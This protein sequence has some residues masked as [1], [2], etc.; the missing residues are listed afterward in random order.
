MPLSNRVR[1]GLVALAVCLAGASGVP[2]EA[3]SFSFSVAGLPVGTMAMSSTT[4]GTSYSATADVDATGLVGF[5]T[6]FFFHGK[7]NGTVAADGTVVPAWF[8]AKSKSSRAVR[9]T[10]IDWKGGTPTKVTIVPPRDDNADPAEQGGTLDPVSATFRLLRDMPKA[11]A[12]NVTVDMFDGSRRSRL[13]VGPAQA[14]GSTLTCKGT[15]TRM[16]GESL[17]TLDKTSFPFTL[18]F[19]VGADGIARA[20]RIEAPTNFGT[21]VVA[22][23]G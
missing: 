16:K 7:A 12:C 23:K 20:Q 1:G 4:S 15:Y 14:K 3:A 21:A 2:A 17:G 10:T 18:T 6:S 11:Q 5:F 22:R 19:T 9:E 13:K 8:Q